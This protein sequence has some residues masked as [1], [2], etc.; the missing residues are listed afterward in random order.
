MVGKETEVS[1]FS[2][3]S[4]TIVKKNDRGYGRAV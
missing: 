2:P 1:N 3:S 4:E